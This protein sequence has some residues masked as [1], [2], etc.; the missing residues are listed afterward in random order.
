M[1][2]A[3]ALRELTAI[4]HE[5]AIE[6]QIAIRK[7]GWSDQKALRVADFIATGTFLALGTPEAMA[8]FT[9][10]DIFDEIGERGDITAADFP[11]VNRHMTALRDY[12]RRRPTDDSWRSRPKHDFARWP[13]HCRPNRELTTQE[14]VNHG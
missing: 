9:I 14:G 12:M 13:D 7:A 6:V 5:H 2:Q 1:S 8:S 3:T 10:T 11:A 4:V